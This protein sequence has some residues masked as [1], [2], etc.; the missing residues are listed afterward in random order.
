MSDRLEREDKETGC[1][2]TVGDSP[3]LQLGE[4]PAGLLPASV[5]A[6]LPHRLLSTYLDLSGNQPG[7]YCK[8]STLELY[9]AVI[10]G[11]QICS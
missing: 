3:A 5:A 6:S 11:A 10:Y 8:I 7:K 1:A 2:E 4:E 9:T